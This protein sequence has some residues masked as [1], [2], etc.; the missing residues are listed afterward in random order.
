M[1]IAALFGMWLS[2]VGVLLVWTTFQETKRTNQI[3]MRENA[4]LT[5]RALAS[6][7]ESALALATAQRNADA[8]ARQV[9][10]AQDTA[11]RQLR[12]YVSV[13]SIDFF[14]DGS[15][16]IGVNVTMRNDGE[17][18]ASDLTGNLYVMIC[19]GG[20]REI[21]LRG[22]DITSAPSRVVLGRGG[23]QGLSHSTTV[24]EGTTSQEVISSEYTFYAF[25]SIQYADIFGDSHET[26]YCSFSSA[27][28]RSSKQ[29][30][31]TAPFGNS[32]T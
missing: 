15:D 21:E 28:S 32:A 8:A 6:G 12:A 5:L 29:V 17:T 4:R 14:P 19:T 2:A 31:C 26:R 20:P 27:Q 16:K 1:G 10:V 24:P 23:E 30:V 22:Q 7:H 25:G 11:K 13:P 3:A 9:E 18:P